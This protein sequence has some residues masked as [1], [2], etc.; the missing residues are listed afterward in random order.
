MALVNMR[1]MIYHAY[2][3][4]YAVGAF[5]LV[6]LDFLEAVIGAAETCRASIV[7]SIAEPHFE[8]Y[9]YELLLPA[10]EAAAQRASVPVAIQLDHGSSLASAIS[11]INR[12]CNGVMLDASRQEL[13]D[14]ITATRAV[15]DMAHRCGVPVTGEVGY[16]AGYEGEG[17]LLHP[18]EAA[19]TVPAEAKAYVERTN[20]D[21]LAVSIGTVQGRMKGRAK[22]DFQRLK[23]INQAVDVPLVIHGGS[24]LNEEQFRKLPSMG[25]AKINYYTAL[26]DV[27]AEA[28]RKRTKVNPDGSFIELKRDVKEAVGEEVERCLR[29]WGS[30]G[31]AAEV[32]TQCRPWAPV[33][34]L[35]MHSA[36]GHSEQA[37]RSLIDEG[38]RLLSGMPGVRSVFTGESINE[39]GVRRFC[40]QLRLTDPRVLDGQGD[41]A[42]FARFLKNRFQGSINDAVTV[43]YQAI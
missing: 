39:A 6:S 22:L 7:L 9:D 8:H 14:N 2:K 32:L 33:E 41:Y 40:W 17:A 38:K 24:G 29:L 13:P 21:F 5:D 25:V 23:L 10:V 28:M 26:S 42:G 31:R 35:I 36:N 1:D 18:G 15:V 12:G 34:H 20:V 4:N 30:A 43:D 11:A 16:V 37:V 3:H 27:A 19:F